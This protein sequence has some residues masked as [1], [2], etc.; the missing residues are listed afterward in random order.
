MINL[1]LLFALTLFLSSI[2]INGFYNIT[3]GRWEV[4]PDGSKEWAGKILSFWG[5]FLQHHSITKEFYKGNEF[6]KQAAILQEF[7]AVNE[8]IEVLETGMVVEKMGCK[9]M[10]VFEVFAASKNILFTT[11][12]Y[13]SGKIISLY[14]EKK[15]YTLPNLVRAP[16]GECLACMS[17]FFGTIC[18][19]IWVEIAIASQV[20]YPTNEVALF[21]GL[22]IFLKII[23]WGVFC[24]SLAYLNETIFNINHKLSK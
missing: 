12:D 13:G 14:R 1:L 18:W 11:R 24:I 15:E 8:I 20:I 19:F 22:N 9:K 21:L 17:S 6:Y 4:K 2:F 23:L 7:F 16:L 3:R 5:K 10:V